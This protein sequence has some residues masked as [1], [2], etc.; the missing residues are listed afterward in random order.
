METDDIARARQE[1]VWKLESRTLWT[2][3]AADPTAAVPMVM[4]GIVFGIPVWLVLLQL[5]AGG[6]DPMGADIFGAA[7]IGFFISAAI[8]TRMGASD[9]K[10][11]AQSIQTM[12][13]KFVAKKYCTEF[14]PD[15]HPRLWAK[16]KKLASEED[17]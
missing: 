2:G 5:F 6:R 16:M 3:L 9:K 15:E 8:A 12:P 1:L 4:M 13:P 14:H 10:Q 17:L 11:K 7:I